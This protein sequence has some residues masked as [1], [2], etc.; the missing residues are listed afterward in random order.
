MAITFIISLLL[1]WF[2]A[3]SL[4]SKNTESK[5]SYIDLGSNCWITPQGFVDLT[6][7]L[8]LEQEWHNRQNVFEKEM[9]DREFE[10]DCAWAEIEK[11]NAQYQ[12]M[13]DKV[14]EIAPED[15][16]EIW[17][18]KWIDYMCDWHLKEKNE[19][20]KQWGYMPFEHFIAS[21]IIPYKSYGM[22]FVFK[23]ML[24]QIEYVV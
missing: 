20:E 15:K 21:E 13:K 4:R 14:A 1:G 7:R 2:F 24:A 12:L 6:P 17:L 19:H 22:K 23:K 11:Q 9:R 18:P 5:S 3:Q 16:L 10:S 8:T